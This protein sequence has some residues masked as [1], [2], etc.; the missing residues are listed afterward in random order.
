MRVTHLYFFLY[1]KVSFAGSASIWYISLAV[2]YQ[3]LLMIC[4]VWFLWKIYSKIR[5]CYTLINR[6]EELLYQINFPVRKLHISSFLRKTLGFIFH[7]HQVV[8]AFVLQHKLY[9][10]SNYSSL[11]HLRSWIF[12]PELHV[13]IM[14]EYRR[15]SNIYYVI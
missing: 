12:S 3:R 9:I 14:H 6:E 5:I 11:V 8:T 4:S 10:L 7:W 1:G 2:N 15:T 13:H